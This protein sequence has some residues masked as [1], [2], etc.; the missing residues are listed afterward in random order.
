[1]KISLMWIIA[2]Y[3]VHYSYAQSVS[4]VPASYSA[5]GASIAKHGEWEAFHNPALLATLEK[6]S[7]SGLYENRFGVKELA[8][9]AFAFSLPAS[10]AHIGA[11]VSH[12]GFSEY[13][14]WLVGIGFARTFDKLFTLGLQFNYFSATL[15]NSIGQKGTVL[16]QIGLLSELTHGFY[17]GFNTFNP[18]R[19]KL[20]YQEVVKVI[21]SVFSLGI[22]YRFSD[23]FQWLAQLD[24]EIQSDLIGRTGFEYR[25]LEFI[26]VRLGLWGAPFTPSIGCGLKWDKL[27]IDVNFE[28]HPVLGISSVGTLRYNF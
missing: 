11:S 5:G 2:L 19:Q 25:L 22:S 1:M 14:E 21:P 28:R 12:F 7:L 27:S 24:K 18:T 6:A 9:Q 8:T 13:S 23:D 10:F 26:R 3:A 16:A 4:V 17:I 15:S 20:K